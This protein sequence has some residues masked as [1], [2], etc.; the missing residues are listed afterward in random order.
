[1]W[2]GEQKV[3]RPFEFRQTLGA[4]YQ[5]LAS[6]SAK[7]AKEAIEATLAIL[8]ED[9]FRRKG[10]KPYVEFLDNLGEQEDMEIA[11]D[12]LDKFLL[13]NESI[14]YDLF[15]GLLKLSF[16]CLTCNKSISKIEPFTSLEL[17]IPQGKAQCSL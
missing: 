13:R 17:P 11:M 4:S 16:T 8:A 9:L 10:K 2:Y 15:L 5:Q 7:D 3:I 12:T 1:M 14:I 6:I